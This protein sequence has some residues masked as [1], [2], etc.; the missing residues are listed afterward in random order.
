[1]QPGGATM[2]RW[3]PGHGPWADG[4][5]GTEWA[6]WGD[7]GPVRQGTSQTSL[8]SCQRP[9]ARGRRC[10][11]A[12][13]FRARH[14]TRPRRRRAAAPG[15]KESASRQVQARRSAGAQGPPCRAHR[16]GRAR[17]PARPGSGGATGGRA[18]GLGRG[19]GERAGRGGRGPGAGGKAEDRDFLFFFFF[20]SSETEKARGRP[21][22]GLRRGIQ[23]TNM[24]VDIRFE[25]RAAPPRKAGER[26]FVKVRATKDMEEDD[27]G[28]KSRKPRS[29]DLDSDLKG[30]RVT[31]APGHGKGGGGRP[32]PAGAAGG[33]SNGGGEHRRIAEHRGAC[34]QRRRRPR[35]NGSG[36]KTN[37][38]QGQG[39]AAGQRADRQ[40]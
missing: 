16:I 24:A 39:Q 12:F 28:R 4:P 36:S 6:V 22:K 30:V 27:R 5:E 8:R 20:F 35:T 2:G 1:M 33:A 34:G 32:A 21:P 10:S 40:F 7:A 31:A 38:G 17:Q 18:G 25:G 37:G 3:G 29:S 11:A 14:R 19:G 13:C 15:A 23:I 9:G 26:S